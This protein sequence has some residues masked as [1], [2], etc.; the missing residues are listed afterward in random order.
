MLVDEP[1]TSLFRVKSSEERKTDEVDREAM[2]RAEGKVTF[3]SHFLHSF[4]TQFQV[5]GILSSTLPLRL[6]LK[7]WI[8]S[9][10]FSNLCFLPFIPK[11]E[12]FKLSIRL[13]NS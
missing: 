11:M 6:L 2:K 4:P 7:Y 3:T 12:C 10:T 5:L 8:N 9:I 13:L 1:L